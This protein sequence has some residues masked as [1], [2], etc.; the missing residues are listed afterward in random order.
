M[1]YK[2]VKISR[3]EQKT[4]LSEQQI[5][6]WH[7]FTGNNGIYLFGMAMLRR[8]V[9]LHK[10]LENWGNEKNT[11]LGEQVYRR[12]YLFAWNNNIYLFGMTTLRRR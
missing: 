8:T 4:S 1:L 11:S 12:R 3:N 2:H 6:R 5:S 7:L 9:M 10:H